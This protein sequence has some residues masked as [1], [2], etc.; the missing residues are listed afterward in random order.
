MNFEKNFHFDESPF[1][2]YVA[3]NEPDILSY[4]VVPPYFDVA[5]RRAITPSS[6]ILFGARG[7]GKSATRLSTERELWARHAS[8]ERT[9][10]PVPMV[11][12]SRALEAK[13]IEDVTSDDL[14]K[15]I[16]FC[17]IESLLLWISDQ[18]DGVDYVELLE[19]EELTLLV[20]LAQVFYFSIPEGGRRL[21][22]QSA[23]RLLR[24]N[25][26]SR[27]VNWAGR[28][29]NAISSIVAEIAS[30][31]AKK[32]AET[33]DLKAEISMLLSDNGS[34]SSHVTVL[35]KL[36]EVAHLFG[37]S[38]VSVFV[39]KVDEHPKTQSS[40]ESSARLVFPI[41]CHVQ[42]LE[43]EGFGWQFFLWDRIRPHLTEG[44]LAIR[45]DK[46]AHS[47]VSWS[48][49]FLRSMLD[50]R[51]NFFSS[52]K[53]QS[54]E[55][56]AEK[57]YNATEKVVE[58]MQLAVHSPRELIRLFDTVA[59]EFDAKYASSTES[60]LLSIDDFD[61]GMDSYVSDVVWGIYERDILSQI[62][63]LEKVKFINKEVQA[64]FKISA[65]GATNRIVKWEASGA[66]GLTGKRDADGGGGGKPS[67]EYS[68]IDPRIVRLAARRLYDENKLTEAPIGSDLN[69]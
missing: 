60:R 26:R 8:G 31:L 5:K 9:P 62:I 50:A 53:V 66:V 65:P 46:I 57:S 44:P 27:T 39:D 63:S 43:V 18:E 28:K 54:L 4:A 55:G 68:V 30:S 32:Y 41:L 6:H 47:E 11:D 51:V 42:L 48:E 16:A 58:A 12:F 22:H 61:V 21:S 24:Q 2:H 37:F 7:A 56:L 3:E 40:A 67:N 15:E 17:T 52:K 25:W 34:I 29:W 20:A 10:L 23:M 19:K 33:K 69:L 1:S 45:L 13:K 36:V 14:I 35:T 49:D 38:G 59:R 64:A